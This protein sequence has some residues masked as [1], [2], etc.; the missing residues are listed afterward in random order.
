VVFLHLNL[1]RE[2]DLNPVLNEVAGYKIRII[3]THEAQK[4]IFFR[5]DLNETYTYFS[6]TSNDLQGVRC[7]VLEGEERPDATAA[8]VANDHEDLHLERAHGVLDGGPDAGVL[9][10]QSTRKRTVN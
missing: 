10:L 6:V 3:M 5:L 8:A 2:A 9:G 7:A 4:F 1:G